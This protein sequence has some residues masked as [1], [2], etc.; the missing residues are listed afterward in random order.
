[1]GEEMFGPYRVES[2]IGRG[3]MGEVHRAYDTVKKRT[4]A[5]KRLPVEFATDE[6]FQARFRRES[7]VAARLR[8]PHVIPIHDFGEIDGRLF[9]D[10]RLVD[11]VDL[12][13]ILQCDGPVDPSRAVQIVGQVGSALDA[14]HAEG[15]VHRDVKPSNVVVAGS[16]PDEFAYLIDFGTA[17]DTRDLL[18]LSTGGVTVGTIAYMAPERFRG[19]DGQ[20][21]ARV[22]VY[23]LACLLYEALTGS[24]PFVGEDA[25]ALKYAHVT[26]APPRPSVQRVGVPIGFDEVVARGLAKD[27]ADRFGSAGE[28]VAAARAVLTASSLPLPGLPA[29]PA[30]RHSDQNPL[31]SSG[32]VLPTAINPPIPSEQSGHNG[33]THTQ[34]T[35]ARPRPDGSRRRHRRR[36]GAAVTTVLII[37]L[38]IGATRLVNGFYVKATPVT[39]IPVGQHPC[40]AVAS[41]DGR[42]YVTNLGSDTVSVID[43]GSNRAIDNIHVGNSPVWAAITPD[44]KHLYVTNSGLGHDTAD[45]FPPEVEDPGPGSVSVID[46]ENKSV[47][48]TIPVGRGPVWEV[49]IPDHARLYVA[50][51]L[52]A[53]SVKR[54]VSVI[55]T[56]S[57]K[58]AYSLFADEMTDNSID[59]RGVNPSWAVSPKDGKRI[60]FGNYDS[61]SVIAVGTMKQS[62]V[63][64]IPYG[65]IDDLSDW[66]S[67]WAVITS[68]GKH[69]YVIGVLS[70]T[71]WVIDTEA[72]KVIET[73]SV[74]PGSNRSAIPA[75]ISK[76][77]K[78]L[79]VTNGDA[80]SVS[81]ID[82]ESNRVIDT[83][84]VGQNPGTPTIT[85]DGKRLFV[86]NASSDS[87]SVIDTG[88]NSVIDTITVGRNP[89]W[90]VITPNGKRLY[91]VNNDFSNN[92]SGSLSVIDTGLRDLQSYL[93][94][95]S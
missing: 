51:Y 68:D 71:V 7:R 30:P 95:P 21:D 34:P 90:A 28:L 8:E 19:P 11:G 92:G 69:L 57:N 17:R 45:C 10:M 20:S 33:P 27:P 83:I 53:K 12:A 42:V 2:L 65:Q 82:T 76:D 62:M 6:G 75:V 22:D 77:D 70:G 47:I 40:T 74:G 54:S 59:K 29:I 36:I 80:G 44:S 5:L 1:M 79:Y 94:V 39:E 67:D 84:K 63:A 24:R 15:L 66:A 56:E 37:S 81:V 50:N 87:V 25:A 32:Q 46:T 23:A 64:T 38:V 72:G 41:S 14:A 55:D 58:V 49:L 48:N 16:G 26:A 73:I 88:S 18:G 3:G 86:I 13:T 9:I 89:S 60:Y 52:P 31:A 93:P 78:R 91:V 43:T 85:A 35:P 4:V 61:N